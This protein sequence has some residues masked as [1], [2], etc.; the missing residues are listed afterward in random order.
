VQWV[1]Q[2]VPDGG[3]WWF[4]LAARQGATA[5]FEAGT[6]V[7]MLAGEEATGFGVP[8]SIA[9]T[10]TGSGS[11]TRCQQRPGSKPCQMGQEAPS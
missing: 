7:G 8:A 4:D 2:R 6:I 1:L 9:G 10:I 11:R 5:L 3:C